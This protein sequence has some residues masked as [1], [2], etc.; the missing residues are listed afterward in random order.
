MSVLSF[1]FSLSFYLSSFQLVVSC[2]LLDKKRGVVILFTH[3]GGIGV[4]CGGVFLRS[5]RVRGRWAHVL[6][7][8]PVFGVIICALGVIAH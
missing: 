4:L 3:M 2:R 7:P 8:S 1:V 5:Q 6:S